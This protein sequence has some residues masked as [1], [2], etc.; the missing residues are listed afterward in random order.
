MFGFPRTI[1]VEV[2]VLVANYNYS[3]IIPIVF[4]FA[5]T[6]L[7][8]VNIH[9]VH[10]CTTSVKGSILHHTRPYMASLIF[11]PQKTN[12]LQVYTG[13]RILFLFFVAGKSAMSCMD[14]CASGRYI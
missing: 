4:A 8:S 12:I 13:I 9:S 1:L 11:L 3:L 6:F 7:F 2:L 10:S 14:A 5:E